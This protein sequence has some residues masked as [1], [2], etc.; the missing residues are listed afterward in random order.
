MSK[1]KIKLNEVNVVKKPGLKSSSR[2]GTPKYI[3]IHHAVCP[4]T[5]CTFTTLK[6]R[7][8]STHYEVDKN[9]GILEYINPME[10]AWHAGKGFNGNSI[11]I[12]LTGKGEEST[13]DQKDALRS[14]VTRLCNAFSIPQ[15]VAPDGVKFKND[16]EIIDLGIGI[17][18]HRNVKA[19]ACPGGFPMEI[20]GTPSDAPLKVDFTSKDK[21]EKEKL[22]NKVNFGKGKESEKHGQEMSKTGGRFLTK[23]R[24]FQKEHPNFSFE[25]FYS[26]LETYLEGGSTAALPNHGKDYVFGPEHLN[27]WNM[28][29]RSKN[30]NLSETK[31]IFNEWRDF[32]EN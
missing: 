4:T 24:Y 15:V 16:Q 9:G 3:V 32:L 17:V 1:L 10:V 2:S 6:Q 13:P 22:S 19:T 20:L 12:D 30:A 8:L 5:T 18:R 7:G 21:E 28:L 27:A 25:K 31:S 26:D 11:G 29:Q 14:L 23:Y